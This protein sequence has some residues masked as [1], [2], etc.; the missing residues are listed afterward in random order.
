[1]KLFTA[2]ALVGA[3]AAATAAGAQ[4]APDYVRMA[5]ASDKFEIT[6]AHLAQQ[7]SHNPRI[8]QYARLMVRDHT[9]ST[10]QVK[11]AVRQTTGHNPPPA[12]L[13]GRERRMV[14]DLRATH[15]REFDR[16][17]VDQQVA[18]HQ[19]ALDLHRGYAEHGGDPELRRTAGMITPVVQ[20]HLEMAHDL[21]SHMR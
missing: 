9:K 14:A 20:Q 7:R 1:M 3:L 12:M 8:L 17:Y 15:G 21:Q 5:G 11:A 18:S 2:T 4:P 10:A 16:T 6:E 13:D 19:E